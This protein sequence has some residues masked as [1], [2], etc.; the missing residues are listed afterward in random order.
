MGTLSDSFGNQFEPQT[1]PNLQ[2]SLLS[3]DNF[4]LA[5]SNFCSLLITIPN[6]L[7]PDQ[8]QQIV[9]PDLDRDCF[10]TPLQMLPLKYFLRELILIKNQQVKKNITQS[11]VFIPSYSNFVRYDC[12]HIE[13]VYTIFCSYLIIFLGVLNLDISMSTSPFECLHCLFVCNL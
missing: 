10:A 1:R 6:S 5:S 7:E 4:F 9:E 12:L 11:P 3:S 13:H 2:A 8:T